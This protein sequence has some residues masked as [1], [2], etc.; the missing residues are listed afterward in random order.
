MKVK[1]DPLR[2]YGLPCLKIGPAPLSHHCKN[3]HHYYQCPRY[4]SA[5]KFASS[6]YLLVGAIT[7]LAVAAVLLPAAAAA[8]NGV[9]IATMITAIRCVNHILRHSNEPYLLHGYGRWRC[10][11]NSTLFI[12]LHILDFILVL[13]PW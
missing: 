5:D 6:P 13:L 8:K 10:R 4:L 7:I 3:C 1:T 12:V 11:Q 2:L 9:T